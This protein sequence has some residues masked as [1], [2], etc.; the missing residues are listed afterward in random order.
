M[1]ILTHCQLD[2]PSIKYPQFTDILHTLNIQPLNIFLHQLDC[3]D[4]TPTPSAEEIAYRES[5]SS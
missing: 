1:L 2:G 4:D 3:I 5:S